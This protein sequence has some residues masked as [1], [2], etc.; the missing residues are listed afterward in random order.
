MAIDVVDGNEDE[1]GVIQDVVLRTALVLDYISEKRQ[2]R[3]LAVHLA[4]M[5]RIL[6]EED[7]PPGSVDRGGVKYAVSRYDHDLQ[8]ASFAGLAEVFN[9]HDLRVGSCNALEV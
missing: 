4:G 6:N 7:G 3:V 1:D 9:P 2:T 5:D 8:V